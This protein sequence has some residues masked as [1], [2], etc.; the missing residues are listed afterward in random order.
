MNG[1]AAPLVGAGRLRPAFPH[2]SAVYGHRKAGRGPAADEGVRPTIHAGVEFVK[3]KWPN[4]GSTAAPVV[5]LDQICRFRG[6]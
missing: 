2:E 1:G 5:E 4:Q 3:T 6:W